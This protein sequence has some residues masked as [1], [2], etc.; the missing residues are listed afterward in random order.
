MNIGDFAL[1]TE[2]GCYTRTPQVVWCVLLDE[3][4]FALV[5]NTN[6]KTTAASMLMSTF[7]ALKF[8][9]VITLLFQLFI[10]YCL[11]CRL[12]LFDDAKL[13]RFSGKNKNFADF[14]LSLLQQPHRFATNRHQGRKRCRI[15]HRKGTV[16]FVL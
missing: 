4:A 16:F 11:L 12:F 8:F 2:S 6:E 14:C 7:F 13:R 5:V 1:W 9:V 15:T 3:L 10:L